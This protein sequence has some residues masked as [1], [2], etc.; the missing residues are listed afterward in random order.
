[1]GHNVTSENYSSNESSSSD[2]SNKG[3]MIGIWV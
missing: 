1:M 3:E 2:D